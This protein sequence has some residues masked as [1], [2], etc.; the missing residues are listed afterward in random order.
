[1]SELLVWKEQLQ[2]LYAKYSIYV[3]KGIQFVLAFATFWFVNS[4]LGY[5]KPVAQPVVMLVL[6]VLCTFLP[7]VFT[8][9]AAAALVVAHL[10][11]LS[12]G[13]AA[14]AA[15]VF[16]LM[17]IFYFRFVPKTGIILL[18]VPIAFLLKIPFA[19]PIIWGLIGTPVMILPVTFGVICYYMI[20][21]VNTSAAVI[22][23]VEG[24]KQ[25]TLFIQ[26]VFQNKEMWIIV[27]AF[28]VCLLVVYALRKLSVD[29]AWEIAIIAGAVV[30]II[31]LVGGE[32]VFDINVSYGQLIFG[33]A[34]ACLIGFAA[35][36]FVFA[37]DYTRTERLQFEDDEYYYYVKAVP[38]IQI[39]PPEKTVKKINERQE[40]APARAEENSTVSSR[41]PRV[42]KKANPERKAA[43]ENQ[44]DS[45]M[46]AA[47]QSNQTAPGISETEELLLAK[48]LQEE[49]ELQNL[50]EN[51]LK[52]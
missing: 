26:K 36:F 21:Y 18:I 16:I 42:R 30:N 11:S 10:F 35:E 27:A 51:E 8:V 39:T 44:A 49:L 20:M 40:K 1:M 32:I 19:V 46:A 4:K 48:S 28:A 2:K 24:M 52:K 31:I 37:V 47:E 45:S 38:K 3:D 22:K 23:G 13:I 5:M 14:A 9:L 43:R 7:T 17:F 41:E 29:H 50:V 15:A 12:I 34:A 6:A 33:N 25:I